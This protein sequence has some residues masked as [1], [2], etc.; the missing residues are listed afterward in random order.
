M[1]R[2]FS[3]IQSRFMEVLCGDKVIFKLRLKLYS[4]MGAGVL[5]PSGNVG[6]GNFNEVKK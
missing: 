6:Q 2:H 4:L 5:S 1:T 3:D